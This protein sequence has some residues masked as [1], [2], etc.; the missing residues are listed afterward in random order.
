MSFEN[1]HFFK[2]NQTEI[3]EFK[4]S[5]EFKPFTLLLPPSFML[6]SP[7]SSSTSISLCYTAPTSISPHFIVQRGMMGRAQAAKVLR[8]IRTTFRQRHTMMHQRC[9]DI[10]AFCHAHLAERMPCQ[11][12][13][14]N[15]MPCSGMVPFLVRWITVEAVV[16]PICFLS[17]F[18]AELAIRQVRA[19]GILAGL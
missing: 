15:R 7:F 16:I 10:P 17:M 12:N 4:K 9:F 14:T 11:L 8:R 13:C 3:K 1:L 2:E 19:A 6:V 18:R 5:N